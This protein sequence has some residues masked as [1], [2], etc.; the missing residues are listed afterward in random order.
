MSVFFQSYDQ[1]CTAATFFSVHSVYCQIL[2]YF[3]VY[4]C[5]GTVRI[6]PASFLAL[7]LLRSF[8]IIVS[9]LLVNVAFVLLGLELS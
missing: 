5:F 1:R 6:E 4:S 9:L 2:Y 8:C 3:S 7:V